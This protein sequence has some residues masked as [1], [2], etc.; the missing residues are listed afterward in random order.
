MAELDPSTLQAVSN[1]NYK[2]MAE[3]GTLLL[4]QMLSDS[5]D[6]RRRMNTI[7]EA[8]VAQ[9]VKG[10]IEVDP[11][12]ALAQVK[13]LTGNDMGKQM[14][15][16]GSAVAALQQIIKAAQSTPPESGK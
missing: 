16:L 12:E 5:V 8:A 11:T 14:T 10:M 3:A 13:Q 15:D 4:H 7:A 2:S 1:A 9:A 6:H